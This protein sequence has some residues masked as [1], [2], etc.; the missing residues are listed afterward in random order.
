[1]ANT[2]S[3]SAAMTPVPGTRGQF[4]LILPWAALNTVLYT[5]K[6]IQYYAQLEDIGTDVYT[7]HYLT[8]GLSQ[9]DYRKDLQAGAALV[10][11]FGDDGSVIYVPDV[12][13]ATIPSQNSPVMGNFVLSALIGPLRSNYNFA[14][15]QQKV[16][17]VLSDYIGLEPEVYVDVLDTATVMSPEEAAAAEAARLAA[18]KNRTSTYALLQQSQ[19]REAALQA[20]IIALLAKIPKSQGGTGA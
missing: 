8:H 13:I 15:M 4:E 3:G 7:E 10:G 9:D 2:S 6:S 1:M 11:L 20:H 17:E 12:Y 16:A 5:C 14:A 19:A 18:I